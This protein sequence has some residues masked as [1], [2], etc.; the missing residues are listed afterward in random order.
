M[1]MRIAT[2][3][4]ARATEEDLSWAAQLGVELELDLGRVV[5]DAP[6]VIVAADHRH[7]DD[8][9]GDGRGN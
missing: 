2:G 5:V 1:A 3:Q 9:I 8:A 4:A 7:A 6:E